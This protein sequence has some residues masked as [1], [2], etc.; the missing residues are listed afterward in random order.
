MKH[1]ALLAKVAVRMP[2]P[3]SILT[4]KVPSGS[5]YA[6]G[7]VVQVP[8]GK[9]KGQGIIV[10]IGSYDDL[11]PSDLAPEK[12]KAIDSILDA[13]LKLG[14]KELELYQW[15][16]KYYHYSLGLLVFDCLPNPVKKPRALP[17]VKGRSEGA[18]FV[19]HPEQEEI[20]QALLP[21]VG[22]GYEKI[23]IH[24]VTGSGKTVIYFELIKKCLELGKSVLLLVPEI[25]LTPQLTDFFCSNLGEFPFFVYHSAI[26]N[27]AK[28]QIRKHLKDNSTPAMVLGVRSSVFLPV[29]NL[30][31]V[32]VDEEHDTSFK[33]SD[34]CP[35]NGRDVAIKKAQL[36]QCLVLLGS[37]TPSLEN[38]YAF[39]KQLPT[40]YYKMLKRAQGAFPEVQFLDAR[41]LKFN[42]PAWPFTPD[43]LRLIS[44]A[45]EKKEQVL[46]FINR[47]G[48]ANYIQCSSCGHKWTDPNTGVN[49]R[50]FKK[51]NIL[52]SA[53]SDYQI[54]LPEMCPKCGNMDLFQ[55]GFGTE[56]AQEV[57]LKH[58][59][60][61]RV[62][63]FDR[64]EITTFKKMKS[65]LDNFQEHAIDILVGTQMLAKGHNFKRVNRVVVL[66]IDSQ[67][68]FPDFRAMERT[69]QLLSQVIGRAGRYSRHSEVMV[70]TYSVDN[71]LFDHIKTH[72]FDAFYKDELSIREMVQLPPFFKLAALFVSARLRDRVI[73]AA[74]ELKDFLEKFPG[75]ILL[76]PAPVMIEKKAGQF[77]WEILIKAQEVN[78]LHGALHAVANRDCPTGITVKIDV[79]PYFTS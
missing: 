65:R 30:G 25:N 75:I 6:P 28:Y 21:K 49:L 24:G 40:N 62:E 32:I 69:Y 43:A 8:L 55:S 78:S 18:T 56:K 3:N 70:Q 77:T 39:K 66:G 26:T 51:K 7:D 19:F 1:T 41:G 37:A 20:I 42:D 53:H 10:E 34:R 50:Y 67:L 31:L 14:P 57:L 44:E 2:G 48:F 76:G 47:L 63:R 27:S 60:H 23:F 13:E 72:A 61:F 46:V 73:S 17:I 54:P 33:Q 11:C 35:Y 45:V 29:Q 5:E 52:S 38:F 22:A 59:S 74:L 12:I 9:R 58:F 15:M 68:N 71:P 79:D 16:A 36:H 64:E 4:Y